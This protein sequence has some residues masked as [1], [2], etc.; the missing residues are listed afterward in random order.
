MET[1]MDKAICRCR[2]VYYSDL[3]AAVNNGATTF[4]EV[5]EVTRVG[6]GCGRCKK[7][8]QEITEHII[9]QKNR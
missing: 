7:Q 9:S 3:E 5:Q 6:K 2:K 1:T 4:E 8:A